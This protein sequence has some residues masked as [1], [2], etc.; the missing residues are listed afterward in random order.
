SILPWGDRIAQARKWLDAFGP[1]WISLQFVPYAFHQKGLCFGLG[2][3]LS[4]LNGKASWHIMFHELWLG[5][6]EKSP[7]KHRVTGVLQ[8]SIIMDCLRRLSPRAVHTQT[9]S[10]RIVLGREKITA[11]ILPLFGNIPRANGDAWAEL[12]EPLI[13]K[14][15]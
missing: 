5:L 15:I 6:E 12:L 10:H 1:D 13:T 14:A 3:K 8:R 11:S 7:V 2:K 4:A 9:E